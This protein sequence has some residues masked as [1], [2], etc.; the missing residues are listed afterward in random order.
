MPKPGTLPTVQ[1]ESRVGTPS[2]ALRGRGLRIAGI[3]FLI[4][5][6]AL[7]YGFSYPFF[8]LALEKQGLSNWLIGLNASLAGVGI[9]FF[10]PFLPR[11]ID[12]IGIGRLVALLFAIPFLSF[13]AILL[14]G[15]TFTWFAARFIMGTCFSALWTTTEIW[16]NGELDDRRRGRIIAASGTLYAACQF[17]GPVLL[18]FSG[19]AG[20]LPLLV[21]MVPLAVG[22]LV[23][24]LLSDRGG[25]TPGLEE[26]E[27]AVSWR[28]AVVL[29]GPILFTAFV[30]GV[31]ETAMQSL[32][33]LYGLAHGLGDAA[34]SGL[35]ATF[36]LGEAVLVIAL[37]WSADR[38]GRRLVLVV[39]TLVAA[40]STAALPLAIGHVALLQA[41]LFLSGGTVAGVYTLGIVL[42]GQDF[43]GQRLAMVS[44]AFGMAYS[45]GSVIGATP[46]GYMIDLAGVEALPIAVAGSFLMLALLIARPGRRDPDGS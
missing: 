35:V 39:A 18:G 41:A 6:E 32:L 13:A 30:S 25:P 8:S 16:L 2:L 27:P 42:I 31:G 19:A 40:L 3:L 5:T 21:A 20:S 38:Y 45:A 33:P 9:L 10:G 24:A 44:T 4:G 36:A 37:G 28:L 26:A 7:L 11:V 29:A 22:A 1:A 12:R 34:A 15:D 17:V 43:R 23:A 14:R 46:I